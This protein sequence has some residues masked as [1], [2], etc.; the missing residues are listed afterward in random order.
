MESVSLCEIETNALINL[1]SNWSR[2]RLRE[3]YDLVC[4]FVLLKYIHIDI[5]LKANI[6]FVLLVFFF[7]SLRKAITLYEYL[8]T[9]VPKLQYIQDNVIKVERSI[10][11]ISQIQNNVKLLLFNHG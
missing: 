4:D 7:A 9:F 2:R 11:N 8:Y 6:L 3:E 10:I 1:G 5:N